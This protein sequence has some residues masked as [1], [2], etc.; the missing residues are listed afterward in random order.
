[1]NG[2]PVYILFHSHQGAA[3]HHAKRLLP[4][5]CVVVRSCN[6]TNLKTL[7]LALVLALSIKIDAKLIV[8]TLEE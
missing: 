8:K 5:T 3:H 7:V 4:V 1:M 6:A 2:Y